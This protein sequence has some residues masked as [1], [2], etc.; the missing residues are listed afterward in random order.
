MEDEVHRLKTD[1][2]KCS[3]EIEMSRVQKLTIEEKYR[4]LHTAL[5]EALTNNQKEYESLKEEVEKHVDREEAFKQETEVAKNSAVA[6]IVLLEEECQRLKG[7]VDRHIKALAEKQF[8]HD[9]VVA[10][11][12]EV[13]NS[14]PQQS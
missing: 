11:L 8:E 3:E 1:Y 10:K 12:I 14:R 4:Q 5:E 13:S 2:E 6:K 9:K 7:S